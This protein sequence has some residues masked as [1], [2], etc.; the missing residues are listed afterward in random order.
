MKDRQVSPDST[1]STLSCI[2]VGTRLNTAARSSISAPPFYSTPPTSQDDSESI[3]YNA[4]RVE[5]SRR[6]LQNVKKRTEKVVRLV[7]AV[8]VGT[9]VNGSA[10]TKD[11]MLGDGVGKLGSEWVDRTPTGRLG[12]VAEGGSKR[13]KV[14]HTA[15]PRKIW[16]SEGLYVGQHYTETGD[17]GMGESGAMNENNTLP[18]PM[19]AGRELLSLPYEEGRNFKLPFDVFSPL[20]REVIPEHWE[21]MSMSVLL[22]PFPYVV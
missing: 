8:G 9:F 13:R 18:L 15:R 10:D 14:Q 16:L 22:V 4:T 7:Q 17:L 2:T 20:P 5:N 6:T 12:N 3:I 11:K 21:N 19:F 1:S